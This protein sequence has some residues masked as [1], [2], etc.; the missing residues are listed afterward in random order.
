MALT[1]M[2][3]CVL[4]VAINLLIGGDT[5]FVRLVSWPMTKHNIRRHPQQATRVNSVR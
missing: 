2:V 1:P 5:M 3:E 4:F